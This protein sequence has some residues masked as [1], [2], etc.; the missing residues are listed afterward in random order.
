MNSGTVRVE[1]FRG[2]W[3]VR[4][5]WLKVTCE[6]HGVPPKEANA[7]AAPAELA[8]IMLREMRDDWK[9]TRP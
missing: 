8:E 3:T 6:T 1:D 2:S 4:D 9:R 5:G 7:G